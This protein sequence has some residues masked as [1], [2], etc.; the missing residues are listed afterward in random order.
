M[1]VFRKCH[2]FVTSLDTRSTEM[3]PTSPA[4]RGPRTEIRAFARVSCVD[5]SGR[6][7]NEAHKPLAARRRRSWEL[8][9]RRLPPLRGGGRQWLLRQFFEFEEFGDGFEGGEGFDVEFFEGFDHGVGLA[10][11]GELE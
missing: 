9:P 2:E 1:A 8:G 3:R 5:I 7:E 11:E 6:K 10:E 4:G